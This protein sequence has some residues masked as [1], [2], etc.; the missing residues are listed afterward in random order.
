MSLGAEMTTD[1]KE[2][3]TVYFLAI[4]FIISY[5]IT[6]ARYAGIRAALVSTS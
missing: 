6:K 2:R 1:Y 3:T 4:V 5:P